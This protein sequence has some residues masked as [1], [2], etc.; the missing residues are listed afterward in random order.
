M[1]ISAVL[2]V[3]FVAS[4]PGMADYGWL[5]LVTLPWA[6]FMDILAVVVGVIALI[7]DIRARRKPW[8]PI[9]ALV[10]SVPVLI[11]TTLILNG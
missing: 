9:A 6:A 7:L 2:L 5:L 10:L 4:F 8:W 11:V 1:L 3:L